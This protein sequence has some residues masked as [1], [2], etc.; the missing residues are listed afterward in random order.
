MGIAPLESLPLGFRFRPT[1]EEL[2]NHYLRLKINGRHSDVEVIP[3]VDVCKWEPWDLPSLSVIKTV[4]PEWFFFC[5]RDRKYP[6]GHRSNRATEA[7]Y[8]KATGKDRTIRS[9]HYKSPSNTNGLIGMKKT[10]VFYRGRAP[11]G[12]RTNWIM[13]EYRPTLNDLD[14]TGPG[15]VAFVLCR[16]FRKPDEK[17]DA[18]KYDEVDQ[19]G[20]SPT[21]TK[22]SPDDASSDLLQETPTS[23]AQCDQSEGIKGWLT[24]KLENMTPSARPLESCSNSYMASDVDDHVTEETPLE[25][26]MRL[27]ENSF[28]PSAFGQ[29]DSPNFSLLQS[30]IDTDM[31]SP[32]PCDFGNDNNGLHFLDG[33]SEQDVSLSDLLDE[34]FHS[35]D[36]SSCEES[37]NVKDSVDRTGIYLTAQAGGACSDMNT[38]WTQHDL[39]IRTSGWYNGQ[40]DE[41][42]C[43]DREV[44]MGNMSHLGDNFVGEGSFTGDSSLGS[45]Y[46]MF[47]SNLEESTSRKSHVDYCGN[48]GSGTGIKIRTRQHQQQPVLDNFVTQGTAPR[49]IR[50]LMN[51]SPQSILNDNVRENQ[52]KEEDEVQSAATEAREASELSPTCAGQVKEF[53]I[54]KSK[55]ELTYR[56]S[57]VNSG[58]DHSVDTGIKIR[59]RFSHQPL[60]ADNFGAQGGAPRRICLQMNTFP[61]PTVNDD[62]RDV[63][64]SKEDYEAQSS[65]NEAREDTEQ[66]SKFNEEKGSPPSKICLQKEDEVQSTISD[67]IEALEQS[68]DSDESDKESHNVKSTSLETAE[69]SST[70]LNNES[71]VV[72][73][74]SSTKLRS[75]AKGDHILNSN[76][77]QGSVSMESQPLHGGSSSSSVVSVGFTIVVI[78]FIVFIGLLSLKA[79]D[80]GVALKVV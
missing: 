56:K 41:V 26:S 57:P 61:G 19:L 67:A 23:D 38:E 30:L 65:V 72:S 14:G 7:G 17:S 1:D 80:M 32:F 31:N 27:E 43:G 3:E 5:P 8:W 2:I 59:T 12:E 75:R 48:Q 21:A 44:R 49:R 47:N 77:M 74:E 33:T 25:A 36:D 11:K 54:Y 29:S 78:L 68:P 10:L 53:A 15:Q 4:D 73:G 42:A 24:D 63:K 40:V 28:L 6:N 79:L 58:G 52:S 62:V 50:L 55:G 35:N 64:Q 39:D 20:L 16:L 69:A 34:V 60:V 45:A 13:H 70:K 22:S 71:R 76:K 46:G 51:R 37:I 66:S 18:L 9:R